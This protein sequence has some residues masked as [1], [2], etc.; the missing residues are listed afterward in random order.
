MKKGL[1][2]AALLLFLLVPLPLCAQD[3]PARVLLLQNDQYSSV[4]AGRISQARR[5]VICAYYL[6]KIGDKPGNL[7]RQLAAELIRAARRGVDVTVILEG[8]DQIGMENQAALKA[9]ARGGV[10]VV[11]PRGRRVTHA[12]AIAI[13]DRYVVIGSHNLTQAALRHNNEL[14]VLLDSPELALEVRRYLERIQ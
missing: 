14:S 8:A 9:L 10:R 2:R 6:F 1:R 7:P 11:N 12:K 13:D 4:L 3:L 5:S